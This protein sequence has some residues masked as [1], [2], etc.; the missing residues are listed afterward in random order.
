MLTQRK[1]AQDFIRGETEGRASHMFI[2][3]DT[4]YSYGRHFP[5]AVRIED[6]EFV[7]NTEK[8]SMTTTRH[9]SIVAT[10]IGNNIM[11]QAPDC[12]IDNIPNFITDEILFLHTKILRARS[13]NKI[14]SLLIYH[15][16]W[17]KAKTRFNLEDKELDNLCLFKN[18]D[19]IVAK[20]VKYRMLNK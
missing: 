3:N 4:I 14:L 1:L 12:I 9:Q 13:N 11:W 17:K 7:Y 19:E 6:F 15:E 20:V 5:I 2:N 16:Y 8:Y 10:A 18:K